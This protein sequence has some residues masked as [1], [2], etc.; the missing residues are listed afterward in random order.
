VTPAMGTK[1]ETA[2]EENAKAATTGFIA[3]PEWWSDE[4]IESHGY[5]KMVIGMRKKRRP[6]KRRKG[7]ET[8]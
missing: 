7:R 6:S 5:E 8:K 1:P 3:V 2:R 4:D